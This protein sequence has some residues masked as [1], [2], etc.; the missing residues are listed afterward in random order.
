[1]GHK[2]VGL[3]FAPALKALADT[4]SRM[5]SAV[6]TGIMAPPVPSRLALESRKKMAVPEG[7]AK[8]REETSKK[9]TMR[10]TALLRCT[11]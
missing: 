7:T 1:M 8:F 3:V 11:S 9:Q 5:S 4:A 10:R 2:S 6:T